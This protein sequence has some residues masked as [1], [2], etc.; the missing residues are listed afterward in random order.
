MLLVH[1]AALVTVE[2]E[3][4]DEI[5]NQENQGNQEDDR[6]DYKNKLK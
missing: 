1:L 5:R 2:N 6:L 3:E 4:Q